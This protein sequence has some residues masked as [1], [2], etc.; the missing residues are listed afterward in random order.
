VVCNIEKNY[1]ESKL[2]FENDDDNNINGMNSNVD[3]K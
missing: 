1:E 3:N 2:K